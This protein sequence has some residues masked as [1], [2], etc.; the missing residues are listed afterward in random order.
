[1]MV[2]SVLHPAWGIQHV[3]SALKKNAMA[4]NPYMHARLSEIHN[5]REKITKKTHLEDV[6]YIVS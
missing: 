2:V 6:F 1:M 4:F 5:L 3:I